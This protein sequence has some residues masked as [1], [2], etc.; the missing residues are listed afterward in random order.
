[1]EAK[2]A[3]DPR[4]EIPAT[5]RSMGIFG[6]LI[7]MAVGLIIGWQKS[8]HSVELPPTGFK[9][10]PAGPGLLERLAEAVLNKGKGS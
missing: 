3:S 7:M 10:P 4:F 2:M 6:G 1:M 9:S 8:G 5:L